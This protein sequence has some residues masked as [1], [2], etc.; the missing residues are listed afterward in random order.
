MGDSPKNILSRIVQAE[1]S[2]ST[3]KAEVLADKIK[4]KKD[5]S[6]KIILSL[7][8]EKTEQ[9]GESIKDDVELK[10]EEN[11]DIVESPLETKDCKQIKT[12][13]KEKNSAEPIDSDLQLYISDDEEEI[14]QLNLNL[15]EDQNVQ[16]VIMVDPED[17]I[18]L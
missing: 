14:N 8:N 5:E 13:Y 4:L 1:Q 3:E 9:A 11:M 15:P 18:N 16:D 7:R 2:E 10:K 17:Q 6:P 12:E